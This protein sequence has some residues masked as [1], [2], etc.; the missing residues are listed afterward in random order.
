MGHDSQ[1]SY[2]RESL[3]EINNKIARGPTHLN[4]DY[5]SI[6]ALALKRERYTRNCDRRPGIRGGTSYRGSGTTGG[7]YASNLCGCGG[8]GRQPRWIARCGATGREPTGYRAIAGAMAHRG[9]DTYTNR[10]SIG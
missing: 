1:I 2:P 6:S 8:P 3:H 9:R 5:C 4:Q 10:F 7:H